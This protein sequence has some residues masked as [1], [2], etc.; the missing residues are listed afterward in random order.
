VRFLAEQGID[1]FL[2]IGTGTPSAPNV[3]HIAQQ[4]NPRSRIVYMDN[5]Q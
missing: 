4:V 1:Q 5:D 2:D 3:H